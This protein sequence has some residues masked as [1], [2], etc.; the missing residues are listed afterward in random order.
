MRHVTRHEESTGMSAEQLR[1]LGKRRHSLAVASFVRRKGELE[2]LVVV[3]LSPYG[4]PIVVLEG[5]EKKLPFG[6]VYVWTDIGWL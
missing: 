6:T 3:E 5:Q 2:A 1:R 4:D